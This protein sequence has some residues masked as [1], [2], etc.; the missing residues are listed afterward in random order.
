MSN[1]KKSFEQSADQGR[2]RLSTL[3]F[4]PWPGIFGQAFAGHRTF[5]RRQSFEKVL[6]RLR[7]WFCQLMNSLQPGIGRRGFYLSM[8]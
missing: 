3:C 8:I 5:S 4:N 1:D 7:R 2:L 6:R